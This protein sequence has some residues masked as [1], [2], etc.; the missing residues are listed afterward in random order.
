MIR[1]YGRE[2]FSVTLLFFLELDGYV[3]YFFIESSGVYGFFFIFTLNSSTAVVRIIIASDQVREKVSNYY[4]EK[5]IINCTHAH[6]R[7][8]YFQF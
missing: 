7:I 4:L 3:R 5:I 6:E 2:L 1:K 8:R